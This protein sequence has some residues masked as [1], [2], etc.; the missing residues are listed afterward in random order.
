MDVVQHI[1]LGACHLK[2]VFRVFANNKLGCVVG[3]CESARGLI[4]A[5]LG[6]QVDLG[7]EGV[8]LLRVA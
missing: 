6:V 3:T 2:T 4:G 7:V 8:V 5:L 1:L